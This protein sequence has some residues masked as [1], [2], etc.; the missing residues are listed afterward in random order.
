[1]YVIPYDFVKRCHRTVAEFHDTVLR[2]LLPTEMET[3]EAAEFLNRNHVQ[4]VTFPDGR[5]ELHG[6]GKKLGDL[7]YGTETDQANGV[8]FVA[9]FTPSE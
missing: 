8:K 1:M 6:F 5:T 9:R 2:S 7:F 3:V 4:F